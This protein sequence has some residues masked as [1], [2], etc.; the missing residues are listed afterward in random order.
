MLSFLFYLH[1]EVQFLLLIQGYLQFFLIVSTQILIL[2][3][4]ESLYASIY[5]TYFQNH[6][7]RVLEMT[8][9]YHF[10][11]S[12]KSCQS[13]QSCNLQTYSIYLLADDLIL[14]FQAAQILISL[15]QQAM[16]LYYLYLYISQ[17]AIQLLSVFIG[18]FH[19]FLFFLLNHIY[20]HHYSF[21]EAQLLFNGHRITSSLLNNLH[22]K[23]H[24]PQHMLHYELI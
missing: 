5:L 17:F 15:L 6:I 23:S 10:Q 8:N 9:S 2:Q 13:N 18:L 12:Q 1:S 14:P 20:L 3:N 11:S 16:K 7:L 22:I 19:A 4:Q 24:I 21:L